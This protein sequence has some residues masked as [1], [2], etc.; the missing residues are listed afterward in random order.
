LFAF[1]F[2]PSFN[3]SFSIIQNI[4]ERRKEEN[5][6]REKEQDE[7]YDLQRKE[8]EKERKRLEKERQEKEAKDRELKK[9]QEMAKE[10]ELIEKKKILQGAG[11]VV[12]NIKEMSD[13]EIMTL[14]NKAEADAE[15]KKKEAAQ[16][17]VMRGDGWVGGWVVAGMEG[18]W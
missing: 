8:A 9:R 3:L 7:L 2:Q 10:M 4:I 5:E 18:L 16:R 1:N 11:V 14:Q 15:N 6:R 17:K 12:D 13:R